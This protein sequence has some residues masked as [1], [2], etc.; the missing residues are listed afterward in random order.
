MRMPDVNEQIKAAIEASGMTRYQISK[1]SGIAQS[2]LSRLMN[3]KQG[4]RVE[5]LEQLA[6]F[7]GLEI[8]VRKKR[9]QKDK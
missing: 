6:D 8:I 4:M 2:Q 9:R 3:D 7:L 5:T 1:E